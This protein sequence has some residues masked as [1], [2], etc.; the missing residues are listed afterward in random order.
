MVRGSE[1][2]SIQ[3]K[4]GD[5]CIAIAQTSDLMVFVLFEFFDANLMV[6]RRPV[7]TYDSTVFYNDC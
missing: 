5:C 7:R 6:F 3:A 2:R 1:T 4:L